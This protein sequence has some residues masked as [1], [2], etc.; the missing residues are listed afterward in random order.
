[1]KTMQSYTY[2]WG[3]VMRIY[4]STKGKQ[5][6]AKNAGS[7]R[8]VYNRMVAIQ[9]ELY[10]L[11]KPT[12]YL[13]PV[14]ERI[15]YL[16]SIHYNA[17]ALKNAIPF[18]FDED[19]DSDMVHTTIKNYRSAWNLYFENP[20][21]G[22]PTFHKKGNTLSYQTSNHYSGTVKN[23]LL[24][25]SIRF[26]DKNHLHL[27]KMGRIRFK[28]SDKRVEQLLSR[29]AETRIGTTTIFR[30]ATGDY[31]VALSI[32]SDTPLC[33]AMERAY[34]ACGFDLNLENFLWDSDGNVVPNMRFK[35]NVQDKISKSKRRLARKI[36]AA[37][38]QGRNFRDSK[39]YQ[40][41]RKHLAELERCVAAERENFHY[42]VANDIVKNHD[43]IFG[44]DLKVSN[45][46]KN[47]HLAYAISDVGWSSFLR[48]L[49]WSAEK[50]GRTMLLVPPHFTTQTCSAC[51]HVMK[52]DE[53]LTL[54]NREWVCPKCK[55]YHIRDYNASINI[56]NR[57]LEILRSAGIKP[58]LK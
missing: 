55:T 2:H 25:G 56:M 20:K 16:S 50:N 14:A 13:E 27:P 8:F 44:E 23:G 7:S 42:T 48:R 45:L 11:R 31:F 17:S 40:K 3:M 39:N 9:N 43:Y 37:K 57:G 26:M 33:S 19:I 47:H 51:G 41:E 10:M 46:L 24:D 32:G 34:K 22:V 5:I 1:M 52:G 38:R 29:T 21:S 15:S 28:T 6:I 12:I 30:D 53:K 18:L 58:E 35:R 36:N 54:G 4:P 49:A